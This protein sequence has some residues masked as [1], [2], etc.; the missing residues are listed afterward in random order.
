ML[1]KKNGRIEVTRRLGRRRTRPL[2]DLKEKR[3]YGNLK[4]EALDRTLWRTRFEREYR[5]VVRHYRMNT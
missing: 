5:P 4:G 2:D 3:G 1:L